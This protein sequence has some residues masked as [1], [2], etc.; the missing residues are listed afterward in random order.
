[1]LLGWSSK[2]MNEADESESTA[3]S[4]RVLTDARYGRF[5]LRTLLVFTTMLAALIATIANY[6]RLA[7]FLVG[8]VSTLVFL[9]F[10]VF[11]ASLAVLGFWRLW[12]SFDTEASND[13]R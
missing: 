10:A 13:E 9:Q 7:L 2:V 12:H 1:M 5:S 3:T 4:N 6:P 8:V 11:F